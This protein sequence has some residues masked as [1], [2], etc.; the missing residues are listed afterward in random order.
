MDDDGGTLEKIFDLIGNIM[1][2]IHTKECS[3][4]RK[5]SFNTKMMNER[6]VL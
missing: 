6:T 2:S 3:R 5:K 1:I 4:R